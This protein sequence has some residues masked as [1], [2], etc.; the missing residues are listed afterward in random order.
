MFDPDVHLN[1][2]EAIGW[3]LGL[4]RMNR[5]CDEL[6][7]PQDRFESIHIVGTNGK[8][9]V[10]RMSAALLDAH[11][12]KS[13]CSV[14]PHIA[15]WSER[16]MVGGKDLDPEAWGAAVERTAD[17]ADAVNETLD[18]GEVVTQ[19][20]AATAAAFLAMA[21]AG[22]EVAAIE[23]GLG[24]RLDATNTIDSSVTV[25]TSI[26]LDHTEFLGDTELEI[27]GEKLAVLKPGTT[28][29][30]GHLAPEIERLA[31][32]HAERLDCDVRAAGDGGEVFEHHIA[33]R[34]QRANFAV[35]A[36]AVEAL[37]GEVD[38]G[39]VRQVAGNMVVPGRLE[40]IG[41]DPP[42]FVDV[43]HNRPG[44]AA[45][46]GSLPE[47]ADGRPVIA[48]IGVLTDKDAAGMLKELAGVVDTAI[49]TELPAKALSDWGRPGARSFP[50]AELKAFADRQGIPSEALPSTREALSRAGNIARERDGLVL[51]AGSHFLLSAVE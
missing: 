13:G 19:F 5:L 21:D 48:V 49:L 34:Y 23:A 25:L 31:R 22:V 14:S 3:K 27:A 15:R 36:L 32:D 42:F 46:A 12:R 20:E 45:L 50:A 4:E 41:H 38:D 6:S 37:L 28:L 2:L 8:S 30:L 47:I 24:G 39:I 11:G 9:S 1:S 51:V 43:A 44:A 40:Q 35:A 33:A 18:E 17:A 16:V 29:V 7:R 10:A 26:G